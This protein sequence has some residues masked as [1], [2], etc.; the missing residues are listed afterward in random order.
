M[1]GPASAAATA[2]RPAR[3]LGWRPAWSASSASYCVDDDFGPFFLTFC[4]YF[5]FNA[6]L[7]LKGNERA[8][9]QAAKAGIGFTPPVCGAALPG[10]RPDGV[11]R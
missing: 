7:C 1:A 4:G 8:K 11:S 9:R 10:A 2:A 6:T 5:P 3:G